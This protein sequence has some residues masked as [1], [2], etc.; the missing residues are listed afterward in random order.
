MSRPQRRSEQR[1]HARQVQRQRNQ[2]Q[3]Q[4]R[5]IMIGGVVVLVLAALAILL[6]NTQTTKLGE[7]FPTQGQEH[8]GRGQAHIAYNSVPPTSGPH[9]NDAGAPAPWGVHE[10]PIENEVQ[11]HNL[12]HGGVAIQYNCGDS[13]PELKQQLAEFYD[14]FTAA[15]KLPLFPGSTKIIVAP[16]PNMPQKISLTAWTRLLK[17]DSWDEQKAVEF[18]NTYRDKGPEAAP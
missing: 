5:Y 8:I 3:K 16:Y 1:A 7:F 10:E 13:C 18:I 12:E 14:R 4:T 2:R 17:M 11:V 9:Y 6:L 15:N